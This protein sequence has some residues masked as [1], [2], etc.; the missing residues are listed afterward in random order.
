MALAWLVLLLIAAAPAAAAPVALTPASGEAGAPTTLLARKLPPGSEVELRIGGG[1]VK[2]LRAD[3]HGKLATTQ[4]IPTAGG[5]RVRVALQNARGEHVVLHYRVG[6]RWSGESAAS[7]A[8]WRGRVMRVSADLQRGKLV[9][10]AE[11]RGLTAGAA[12]EATYAGRRV[13]EGAA[14]PTGHGTLRLVLPQEAAGRRLE[15]R[16]GDA[17]LAADLPVPPA[18]VVATGDIACRAPYETDAQHCRHPETA[19]L[20]D[21][22]DPDV[23]ALAGD[24][25]YESGSL[26]E[27]HGSFDLTWGRL[28]IPL[29]PVPGNHEY[30]TPGATGFYDYFAEQSGWRP[31]P[32]YAYDVGPWRLLALNSNCESGRADCVEE[33]EWLRANLVA[34]PHRCTLAYWHHPRYS[35][36]FHGSDPRTTALWQ[37]LDAADAELV[38]SGHDH[39]YERFAPQD[40]QGQ[41]DEIG[42]RQ[43]VVGTGGEEPSVIHDPRAPHSEYSQNREFGVLVLRLY[44]DAYSWRFVGLSGRTLDRGNGSCIQ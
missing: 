4:R 40:A 24:V 7:G 14:G 6:S 35:S 39:D 26:D 34:E 42:M 30:R 36:G 41:H 22:L 20:T 12:L 13:A 10:I 9:V 33:N 19:W 8:D 43:F 17:Q 18:T 27:F 5:R 29:R 23:I 32:W 28:D 15:V 21:Q 25:Q 3:A 38:I 1:R 37:T 11:L 2:E 31:P 44:A 16:A